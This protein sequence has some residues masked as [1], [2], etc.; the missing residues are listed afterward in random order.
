M[1]KMTVTPPAGQF[2][3][4]VRLEITAIDDGSDAFN[5]AGAPFEILYTIDGSIPSDSNPNTV[6]RRSP[7]KN[8][9]ID[10][11]TMLK[12]FA[13]S[14][15]P[16]VQTTDILLQF[17]DLLELTARNTIN[18][19]DP[20]VRNYTLKIDE[21]GDLVRT[22]PGQY[23]VVFGIDKTKQDVRESILV[24]NVAQGSPVGD[25]TL[26]TF[27]SALNRVFG[28]SFPIGFAASEIQTS[29]FDAMNTL[30]ALQKAERVP[31][32]E[33]IRRIVSISVT[34]IDPTTFKYRV[35][36]ETVSGDVLADNGT[37]LAG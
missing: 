28:Q 37:L 21:S 23:D 4:F 17:Y 20:S 29:L 25:R 19:V 3:E 33:Q 16:S 8:L 27:G 13:R 1:I 36:V 9:P 34:P 35:I 11:P 32:N 30:M 26:P 15:N 6:I 24:E 12:V 31:T 5:I 7:V 2:I 10:K 22:S 14:L 18:T